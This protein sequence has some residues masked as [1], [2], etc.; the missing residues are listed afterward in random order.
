MS[1]QPTEVMA[2]ARAIASSPLQREPLDALL[3]QVDPAE[4]Y[5]T[6]RTEAWASVVVR[7]VAAIEAISHDPMPGVSPM[8]QGAVQAFVVDV[9]NESDRLMDAYQAASVDESFGDGSTARVAVGFYRLAAAIQRAILAVR[10]HLG[11]ATPARLL[12]VLV[13]VEGIVGQ[14]PASAAATEPPARQG[15]DQAR[16][17]GLS[18]GMRRNGLMILGALAAVMLLGNTRD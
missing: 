6:T 14:S 1:M 11:D 15:S 2:R 3:A 9:A 7:A 17:P 12:E 4:P 16:A 5:F 18:P 10:S 13:D 8:V